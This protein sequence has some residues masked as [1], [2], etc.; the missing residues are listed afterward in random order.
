MSKNTP[1][2]FD[3]S[4]IDTCL[5]DL[6]S[7]S[8]PVQKTVVDFLKM[9]TGKSQGMKSAQP[10]QCGPD[11]EKDADICINTAIELQLQA[12]AVLIQAKGC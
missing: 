2:S 8:A 3:P 11:G 10:V 7:L 5:E 6:K 9:V 12:L 4:M 1:K